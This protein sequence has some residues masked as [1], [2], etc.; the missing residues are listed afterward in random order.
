MPQ[1]Q[2]GIDCAQFAGKNDP[3]DTGIWLVKRYSNN[4][5]VLTGCGNEEYIHNRKTAM[6]ERFVN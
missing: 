6:F 5:I 4:E 3:A 1:E 2:Y